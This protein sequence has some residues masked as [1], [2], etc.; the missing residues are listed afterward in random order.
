MIVILN[1]LRALYVDIEVQS[2]MIFF[3]TLKSFSVYSKEPY[4]SLLEMVT[5]YIT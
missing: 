4:K 1:D 3:S 2:K 5:D